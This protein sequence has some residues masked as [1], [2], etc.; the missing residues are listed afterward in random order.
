MYKQIYKYTLYIFVLVYEGTLW[1]CSHALFVDIELQ[2]E[3]KNLP[4]YPLCY[5]NYLPLWH[6]LFKIENYQLEFIQQIFYELVS[7]LILFIDQLNLN[8]K[9]K[10]NKF[11][12]DT[13]L[14]LKAENE[15]DFRYFINLVDLYTQIFEEINI[16]LLENHVERILKCFIKF[17]YKYPMVS[18]FYKLIK[19]IFRKPNIFHDYHTCVS[20]FT[21]ELIP[22]YLSDVIQL[23]YKFSD[24]LQLS[25]IDL[26]FNTPVFFITERIEVIPVFKI[27]LKIGLTDPSL[28]F[29]ALETLRNWSNSLQNE[30]LTNFYKNI[31]SYV[32]PYLTEEDFFLDINQY[33]RGNKPKQ[34]E[35]AIFFNER[36]LQKKILQ[37]CCA[38]NND[39]VLENNMFSKVEASWNTKHLLFDLLFP[40][41][42][43]EI[44][45]DKF[46]EQI[47]YLIEHGNRRTK[48]SACELLHTIITIIL[49]KKLID[50]C[51]NK[52]LCS[53]VLKLGCESD[54][55]IKNLYHPLVIQLTHY[56][57]LKPI[58]ESQMSQIF[59]DSLFEGLTDELN[60]SL[61]DYCGVCLKEFVEWTIKQS[62]EYDRSNFS[63]LVQRIINFSLSPSNN[64]RLAAAI[65]FNHLCTTLGGSISV[66]N[67]HWLEFLYVFVKSLEK[68][69]DIR[70]ISAINNVESVIKVTSNTLNAKSLHR[71]KPLGF[72]NETLKSAT[73]WL[74]DQCG[75]LNIRCRHKSMELFENLYLFIPGNKSIEEFFSSCSASS[76]NRIVLK[77]LDKNFEFFTANQ[78]QTFLKCLDFYIW[79]FN[80]G[81][82]TPESI[83]DAEDARDETNMFFQFF[84]KFVSLVINDDIKEVSRS[85]TN[86]AKEAEE[87]IYLFNKA[88]LEIFRFI[89]IV[90]LTKVYKLIFSL[91]IRQLIY[92]FKIDVF[93]IVLLH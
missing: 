65:A 31:F 6:S 41:L 59:I 43:I 70:I 81:F 90:L 74:F 78:I 82:L 92:Y 44:N 2:Q 38:L 5:K 64:K 20:E 37:I 49:G 89:S 27:A 13:S 4:E 9:P 63:K 86:T 26:I 24:E 22:Q 80:K 85:R 19:V 25:C 62:P 58:R 67:R 15:A 61:K 52:S 56:L 35:N 68:C 45:F 91:M 29:C 76:I 77:N 87:L 73:M 10:Q 48:F 93:F 3:I 75:S 72:A 42:H 1:S 66:I 17:S 50:Q 7:V 60:P 39:S 21:R 47:K 18:G 23:I 33:S 57:S 84:S 32:E 55:V 11:L 28:A 36:N 88:I 8:V 12:S 16:E 79:I 40:D 30:H 46:I 71:E 53:T 83:F 54:N 14:S 34:V 51:F 69:D